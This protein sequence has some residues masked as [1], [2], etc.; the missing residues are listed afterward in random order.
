MANK[1]SGSGIYGGYLPKPAPP[2]PAPKPSVVSGSGIYGGYPLNRVPPA[3]APPAA[4]PIA[5]A[6]ADQGTATATDTATERQ[7]FDFST[8]PGYL[9]SLAAEQAGSAQLD[10]AMRAQRERALVQFGDPSLAGAF[11]ID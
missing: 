8:D 10:A 5:A 9:A 2:P 6:V 4:T 7:P 11:G 3:T 1:V